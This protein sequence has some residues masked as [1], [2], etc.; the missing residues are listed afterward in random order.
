[1]GG[2]D[3]SAFDGF[4]DV[5]SQSVDSFFAALKQPGALKKP[6][7]SLAGLARLAAKV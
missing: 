1:M 7:S 3:D 4:D 2:A 5:T 6:S